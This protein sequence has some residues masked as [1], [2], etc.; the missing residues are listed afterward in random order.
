MK[1][2]MTKGCHCTIDIFVNDPGAGICKVIEGKY[3]RCAGV[4]LSLQSKYYH[5]ICDF[6]CYLNTQNNAI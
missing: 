1:F 2:L 6:P 4:S 5:A 3:S